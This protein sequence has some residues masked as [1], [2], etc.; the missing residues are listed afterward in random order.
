[1]KHISIYFLFLFL[2]LEFGYSSE[3]SAQSVSR[4]NITFESGRYTL[5][6]ELLLPD[7]VANNI[8]VVVFIVGSGPNSSHRTLYKNFTEELLEA[9]FLNEG[10]GILYYDKRGV[11]KSDGR[12]QRTSYYEQVDDTKAAVDFLK[13]QNRVDDNRVGIIGHSKGGIVAQLMGALYPEDVNLIA[14]LNSP[15]FDQ[16]KILEN[17]YYSE[18]KCAGESDDSAL[19]KAEK[20]AVSDINW[21]DWFPL[22]KAWRHLKINSD[23]DPENEI[24]N[25]KVPAFYAFSENDNMVYPEWALSEL[26]AIF[27]GNIPNNFNIEVLENTNSDL[28]VIGECASQ[29]E[30]DAARYSEEFKSLFKDWIL[31]HL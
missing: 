15:P 17:T 30:I 6:G 11:G 18:Y 23:F 10:V 5:H 9:L 3:V 4:T 16:Y 25:I 22:K 12:W 1:M 29:E 7:S 26:R 27:N 13:T 14:A 24:K 21:V 8:P 19:D 31:N 20:K 28:K 2:L